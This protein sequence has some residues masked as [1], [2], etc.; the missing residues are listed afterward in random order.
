MKKLSLV[1][2]ILLLSYKIFAQP[3]ISLN[4][5][6]TGLSQPMQFINAGD[7][8]N[9]I[10]IPQK[11][12]DI[13]VF[14]K[15]FV[16][17]GNFLSIT[18][19]QTGGEQGLLSMCFHPQYATNGLFFVY[20]TNASSNLEVA[21]YQVGSGNDSINLARPSSKRIVITIPHPSYTNHNGGTLRFGKDGYLYLSTGDGG[22]GGDPLNNA[23]NTSVLLG[24]IIRLNVNTSNTAPYY[25]IGV[26][27][28][29][30]FPLEF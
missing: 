29:K 24:K 28:K 9:R 2:I 19:I 25:S 11:G 17:L 8:S 5:V 13:K 6:I 12:G 1:L 20:Y 10:F 3:N 7:G 21:R 30:S 16:S 22:S 23:Q 18:G 26:W 27:F 15:N 14:N 4:Q